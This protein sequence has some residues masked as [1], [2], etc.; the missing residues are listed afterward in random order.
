M[1]GRV[2]V[3][4]TTSYNTSGVWGIVCDDLWGKEEAQVVCKQLNV[5][6]TIGL[7]SCVEHAL[8]LMLNLAKYVY[9]T[10]T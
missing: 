7:F 2:E 3:F 9:C 8:T 1:E 4:S 6:S 5:N 10:K